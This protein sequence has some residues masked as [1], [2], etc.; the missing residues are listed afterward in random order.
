MIGEVGSTNGWHEGSEPKP[1]GG[2]VTFKFCVPEG[3]DVKGTAIT[4]S[5]DSYVM[6]EETDTG[7]LGEVAV[8]R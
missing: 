3:S 4:V 8:W 1:G 5:F 2:S 6:G 7:Y